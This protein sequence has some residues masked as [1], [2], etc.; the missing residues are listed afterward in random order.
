MVLSDPLQ[1]SVE[2][3]DMLLPAMSIG[4]QTGVHVLD[5]KLPVFVFYKLEILLVYVNLRN[6]YIS[7]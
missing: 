5:T 1:P 3:H 6:N 4:T 7:A 2:Q